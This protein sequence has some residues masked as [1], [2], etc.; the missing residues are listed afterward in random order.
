MP[1]RARPA[2]GAAAAKPARK[3]GA[4]GY[5]ALL[6]GVSPMNA[7]MPELKACFEAAGFTDVK[8]VLASGNVVFHAPWATTRTIA[9]RAAAA[10]DEHLAYPF[11]VIV[12]T[13][14]ELTAILASDPW[15]R[16]RAAPG[17]KRVVTFLRAPAPTVSL[18][19]EVDGARIL[20]A[21]GAEVF[22][23]YLPSPRGP[24]FMRLIEKAFGKDITTRTWE[25]VE[26]I[27]RAAAR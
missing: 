14:E 17:A 1:T 5:A 25:T 10:M 11:P 9:A 20:A 2:R 12:R 8:T 23:A 7:R 15:T 18:P 19:E 6:R 22:T 4:I 13:I 26:K 21:D 3:G 27:V 24:V 16:L